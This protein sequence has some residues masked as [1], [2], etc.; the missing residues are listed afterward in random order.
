MNPKTRTTRRSF[1][2]GLGTLGVALPFLESIPERS[3]FAQAAPKPVF[4]FFICTANGVVQA[5]SNEPE[6]FWPTQV[7][8]LTTASMQAF[9]AD[10]CTGLL[11]DYASKLLIVRGI[12]YPYNVGGCGHANGLVQSLTASR[13]TGDSNRA[14]SSGISA[15]TAIAQR[16][17]VEPLT[18]Y[19]GMKG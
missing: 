1:L 18:L 6:K 7:G 2:R 11:A 13:P 10:R 3:A 5:W 14:T 15:D 9:A 16:L 19:S 4:A 12:N 8:P 17:K